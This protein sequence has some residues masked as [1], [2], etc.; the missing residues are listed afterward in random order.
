[1]IKLHVF[2][3]LIIILFAGCNS[4]SSQISF[5][6]SSG[7]PQSYRVKSSLQLLSNATSS[8]FFSEANLTFTKQLTQ[9]FDDNTGNFLIKIDTINF[10]SNQYSN[11]ECR[12]IE[13][14]LLQHNTEF[15]INSRG[16]PLDVK[17]IAETHEMEISGFNLLNI[18]VKMQPILPGVAV[19]NGDSWEIEHNLPATSGYTN[20]LNKWFK[21]VT[22]YSNGGKH[23]A[24]IMTTLKYQINDPK[25]II[26]TKENFILGQG[27]VVFNMD[28]GEIEFGEFEISGKVD[29]TI[30]EELFPDYQILQSVSI[31]RIAN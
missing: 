30:S 2:S 4:D 14:H 7:T 3:L 13:T 23:F 11:E 10:E 16:E 26:S 8:N 6:L 17:N 15:K 28:D 27:F 12:N 1:M 20:H 18:L 31:Q 22:I 9:A 24:R 29:L 5:N 25:S 21:I 19:K